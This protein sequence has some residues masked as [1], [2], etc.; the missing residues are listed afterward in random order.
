MY[1]ITQR[2]EI[3][4]RI[5]EPSCIPI[6][7]RLLKQSGSPYASII[8]TNERKLATLLV[9]ALLADISE[10]D[11]IRA[12]SGSSEAPKKASTAAVSAYAIEAVKKNAQRLRNTLTSA[13][14]TWTILWSA[15]RT[16]YSRTA[17]TSAS[18][19]A[20]LKA[21]CTRRQPTPRT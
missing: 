15:L 7:R 11:I 9:S 2:R 1:S 4:S 12:C 18:G 8:N 20:K 21:A 19:F 6:Y 3:A 10:E 17:S 14:R 13:G 5:A 16:L